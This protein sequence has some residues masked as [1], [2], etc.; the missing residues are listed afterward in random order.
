LLEKQH[1]F[2]GGEKSSITKLPIINRSVLK[3]DWL[4]LQTALGVVQQPFGPGGAPDGPN[5]HS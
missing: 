2:P 1:F 3:R 4:T 5:K